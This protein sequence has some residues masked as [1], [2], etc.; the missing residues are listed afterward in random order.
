MTPAEPIIIYVFSLGNDA[1]NAEFES[2]DDKVRLT[3]LPAAIYNAYKR[4]LPKPKDEEIFT[5]ETS[6]EKE[7][8][9]DLGRLFSQG[10]NE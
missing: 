7:T 10:G 5:E 3:A 2:V 8:D 4:V 6:A 1:W 9:E